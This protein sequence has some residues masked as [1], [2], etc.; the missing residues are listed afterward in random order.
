M[1]FPLAGVVL[2]TYGTHINGSTLHHH[3]FFAFILLY[4]CYDSMGQAL[5]VGLPLILCGY[6]QLC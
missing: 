3:Y 2:I 5:R 1:N 4:K 6:K